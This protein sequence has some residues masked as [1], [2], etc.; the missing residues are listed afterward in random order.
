VGLGAGRPAHPGVERLDRVVRVD[1][2]ADL[3]VLG[4]ER[5]E[6]DP[7]NLWVGAPAYPRIVAQPVIYFS[8]IQRKGLAPKGFHHLDAVADRILD[9]PRLLATTATPFDW[10][11]TRTELNALLAR[12]DTHPTPHRR[13]LTRQ[14]TSPHFRARTP[15]PQVLGQPPLETDLSASAS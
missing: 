10:K 9:L 6:L 11:F 14:D 7:T 13:S 8:I 4:Q 15:K 12:I 1:D 3:G 2:P 5:D